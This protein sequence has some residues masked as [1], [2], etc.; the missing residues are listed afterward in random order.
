MAK[1]LFAFVAA[2][3]FCGL[4]G[5]QS[6]SADVWM[7]GN[8]GLGDDWNADSNDFTDDGG[9]LWSNTLT[10]LTAGTRYEFKIIVDAD[11]NSI[12]EWAN[13]LIVPGGSNAAVYADAGG[14]I[15]VNYDAN[16]QRYLVS[17]F[18][19]GPWFAVGDWQDEAGA[20]SDWN[21]SAAET[22]LAD[23]GGGIYQYVSPTLAAGT[24]QWKAT[25]NGWDYQVG[26]EGVNVNGSTQEFTLDGNQFVTMTLDSN[27]QSIGFSITS[28]PEPG[29]LSV[30]G[31][32]GLIVLARRRR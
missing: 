6:A 10:G 19:T 16:T 9:G 29:S 27:T 13:D 5:T 20:S 28:V 26:A 32:V 15:T 17:N 7:P 11:S 14:E 21:N 30:V 22:Q 4:L 25:T 8:W 23:I 2:I 31:V 3:A 18:Q 12:G 1:Y 24:Y